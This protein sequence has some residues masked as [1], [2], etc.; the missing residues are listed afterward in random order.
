MQCIPAYRVSLYIATS[1]V[2]AVMVVF[3][4]DHS[5]RDVATGV[6]TVSL[7]SPVYKN[8]T[9]V[10]EAIYMRTSVRTFAQKPLSFQSISQL[11]WAAGGKNVDGVSGASRTYPSAGG[12]YP[13]EIYLVCTDVE[14]LSSGVYRYQWKDHSLNKYAAGPNRMDA[15]KQATYSGAFI[16][17]YVPACIV[18]TALYSRTTSKYGKRGQK[19]YV[20]MDAGG[21]AQNVHLQA[22]TYGIGTYPIGAFDD[23][24]VK[25][26]IGIEETQ[27]VPLVIIPCGKRQSR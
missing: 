1:V 6:D 17:S 22:H 3:C 9:S 2:C 10:A 24:K 23:M 27:Q 19:R 12:L 21:S 26:A 13:L 15:L 8:D 16:D 25:A 5:P 20:P 14:S 4:A 11:L 7:A 18:I